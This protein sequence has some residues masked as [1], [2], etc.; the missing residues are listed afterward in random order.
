MLSHLFLRSQH[1]VNAL[2]INR[3]LA[4]APA[5]FHVHAGGIASCD[6]RTCIPWTTTDVR[7][8]CFISRVAV[9]AGGTVEVVGEPVGENRRPWSA[10]SR[11]YSGSTGVQFLNLSPDQERHCSSYSSLAA[12]ARFFMHD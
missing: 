6:D 7:K 2:E 10:G 11:E 9:E 5:I 12:L 3:T 8:T 4:L 1:R